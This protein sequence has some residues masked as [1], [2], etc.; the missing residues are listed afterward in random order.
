MEIIKNL[1]QGIL[2]KMD[3]S[4]QNAEGTGTPQK[5]FIPYI[6]GAVAVIIILFLFVGGNPTS[7]KDIVKKYADISITALNEGKVSD[8]DLSW[9][10][11]IFV[12]PTDGARESAA[13][14]Q[15]TLM[16]QQ[17]AGY[18]GSVKSKFKEIK[19][20]HDDGTNCVIGVVIETSGFRAG[21]SS[22]AETQTKVYLVKLD[23]WKISRTESQ[24]IE[25]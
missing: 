17:L 25:H 23:E 21:Y 5:N 1:L 22:T 11:K 18:G 16:N 6:A 10:Q 15:S 12:N 20:I 8:E 13:M 14:R 19:I 2:N 4:Q 24:T 7:P 9:L 3:S